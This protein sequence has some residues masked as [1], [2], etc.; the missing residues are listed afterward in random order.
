VDG[1]YGALAASTNAKR[2]LFKGIEA[3]DSVSLDPHKWLYT[4]LGCGCLLLREPE[5][6]R[7]AFVGTEEGYIKVFERDEAEA[8]AFWDYGTELSRPFRALK[9]WATLCYYGARR[10]AAAIEEDCALAEYMAAR[11]RAAEDFELLAP[12]TLGI[13][14]FRYGTTAARRELE[15]EEKREETNARLDSLNERVMHRVQRG[16]EA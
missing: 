10:L 1:A 4:P 13:C 9:V 14:C 15:D 3:A 8:F 11:V 2:A 16:G 5:R 12:V 7:A 6:A